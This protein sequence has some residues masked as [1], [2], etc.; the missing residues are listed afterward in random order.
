[1]L[2]FL[3][4]T[5]NYDNLGFL[6]TISK[7]S[8]V[9]EEKIAILERLIELDP[10]NSSTYKDEIMSLVAMATI[11]E[12]MKSVD[13]SRIFIDIP[14]IKQWAELH[15]LDAF[16]RYF[17]LISNLSVKAV[18]I[19]SVT[20]VIKGIDDSE[21]VIKFLKVPKDESIAVLSVL[22]EALRQK[23][24]FDPEY[25]L[26]AFLS[27]RVR[28]G[29]LAGTLRGGSKSENLLCV[30][31]SIGKYK[32]N[33]SWTNGEVGKTADAIQE[34]LEK[35]TD[36]IEN[37][38]NNELKPLFYARSDKTP[39]GM[40]NSDILPSDI[41]LLHSKAISE[42]ALSVSK[43]MDYIF[44]VLKARLN[45]SLKD[46]R[47]FLDVDGREMLSKCFINAHE[48]VRQ[49]NGQHIERLR[50]ALN[51][52]RHL[53]NLD[54]DLIISWLEIKDFDDLKTVF[55]IEQALN[56]GVKSATRLLK[57]FDPDLSYNILSE[58]K[59][60]FSV[61]QEIAD[62]IFIVMDNVFKYSG[63]DNP[64]V[65]IRVSKEENLLNINISTQISES[66]SEHDR[67]AI[68]QLK[69]RILSGS[70]VDRISNEGNSGFAK[71]YHIIS[72]H[73]NHELDFYYEDRFFVTSV[74]FS[75][76]LIEE[77]E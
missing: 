65:S 37:V 26:N 50:N 44:E 36:S 58:L 54:L 13:K 22:I 12:G 11:Q 57:G 76:L 73:T 24:L 51:T 74:S 2:Y 33:D 67:N 6:D 4:N 64:S 38:I 60:G 27:M 29:T 8:E 49:S 41:Y 70:Y 23:F 63:V 16:T 17:N 72:S 35:L 46:L 25:G 77:V 55:D 18:E 42:N 5:A 30:K 39:R 28:H 53:T 52:A 69:N 40:M 43:F 56:I 20:A 68:L 75:L 59:V 71:I 32:K 45:N 15:L 3:R 34:T 10:G 61:V 21:K 66:P 7:G 14:S 31:N 19:D 1:M 9:E 62:I 47:R 48:Q